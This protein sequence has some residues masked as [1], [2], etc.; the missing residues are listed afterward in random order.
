MKIQIKRLIPITTIIGICVCCCAAFGAQANV[1]PLGPAVYTANQATQGRGIYA[2]QCASCHG[3]NL[4][5]N[6]GP[7]LSGSAF[8][9]MAAAQQLTAASLLAVITQSM[10][11]IDPGSLSAADY[12]NVTA[13]ILK[14]N[15]FAAGQNPLSASS[16]L[17][18]TLML[19][20]SSP[21]SQ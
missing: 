18:Q 16:P 21:T 2:N 12:A 9:Q 14:E 11:K 17:L 20:K 7:A 5:G 8:E 13:Y 1:S 6:I 15:N 19:T 10:P 3:A 4:E